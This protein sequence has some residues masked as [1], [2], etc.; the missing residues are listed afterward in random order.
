MSCTLV[1]S[2]VAIN[3]RVI[4]GFPVFTWL[5]T[6]QILITAH[7]NKASAQCTISC[8]VLSETVNI[9]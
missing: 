3:S 2:K 5:D 9:E 7:F 8:Y 4:V 1:M 6:R